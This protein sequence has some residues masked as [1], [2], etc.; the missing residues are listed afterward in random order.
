MRATFQKLKLPGIPLTVILLVAV[1]LAVLGWSS[2]RSTGP[3]SAYREIVLLVPDDLD[4]R[5]PYYL[6]W[7]D[8]LREEGFSYS[9][10]SASEAIRASAAGVLNARGLIMPDTFHRRAGVA[11]LDALRVEVQRGAHLLLVFD[12]AIAS[13]GGFINSPH[14]LRRLAGV[15][16]ALYEDEGKSATAVGKLTSNE[17][18]ASLL[19]LPPG[20]MKRVDDADGKAQLQATAYGYEKAEFSHFV[21]RKSQAGSA[22]LRSGDSVLANLNQIGTGLVLFVNLPLGYLKS[23]TDAIWL[24]T[25]LRYFGDQLIRS[26][27]LAAAPDAVGGLVINWHVD[28]RKALGFLPLL[29]EL[30]FGDWGPY[31]IH[32]TAGPDTDAYG[33]GLGMDLPNNPS[34]QAWVHK[35][36][37]RGNSFGSHG[38]WIHNVFSLEVTERSRKSHEQL[39]Y[40]NIRA[41]TEAVGAEI[42]EYSA[43]SGNHP[44]WTTELI[45]EAGIRAYYTT[46]NAGMGPTRSYIQPDSKA[47]RA[48]SFPISALDQAASFEEANDLAVPSADM[49]NWLNAL[50]EFCAENRVV[51]LFY[52]HPI[53]VSMYKDI[54]GVWLR[55]VR[56]RQNAEALRM[57]TMSQMAEFLD[58]REAV[59]FSMQADASGHGVRIE[60]ATEKDL[61]QQVLSLPKS[62]FKRPVLIHGLGAVDESKD[63]WMVHAGAGQKLKMNVKVS[64]G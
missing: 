22:L 21:T 29:E 17:K 16:Y 59:T 48:W 50:S 38:G 4:A 56:S 47:A 24:H 26:P 7:I 19:R 18:V 28:D 49:L 8:A 2:G 25:F 30:G 10:L 27:R 58:R 62:R 41:V 43:P 31:S 5:D 42:K 44:Q 12:A 11:L 63:N 35:M 52:F 60:L 6:S 32:L 39:I 51:R 53:G 55:N 13:P 40:D 20:R 15:D 46:G 61:A 37:A 33:D 45:K 34:M 57:Y 9:T 23:R 14:K 3:I 54:A 36:A 1:A 64:R